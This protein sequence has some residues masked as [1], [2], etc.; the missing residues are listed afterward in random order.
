MV[1]EKKQQKNGFFNINNL[2]PGE[3][4]E[5]PLQRIYAKRLLVFSIF[6]IVCILWPF[7][8]FEENAV[9]WLQNEKGIEFYGN[10][11]VMSS[12]PP[13]KLFESLVDGDGFSLEVWLSTA[14]KYQK[15]PARIISY[16]KNPYLR[17]FTLAQDGHKLVM[18]LRTTKTNKNGVNPFFTVLDVFTNTEKMHIAITYDGKW[19]TIYVNGNKR[20]RKSIPGGRFENWDRKFYL[21]L[22][23]EGTA[24]RPWFGK[25]FQ[26]K[27]HN[28]ILAPVEIQQSYMFE[29]EGNLE[30]YP[31]A[32]QKDGL[33]VDYRFDEGKGSLIGDSVGNNEPIDLYLPKF[34]RKCGVTLLSWPNISIQQILKS[35]DVV[36]NI[37][38]FV[39]FGFLMHGVIRV[40][41]GLSWK[42][43]V[44]VCMSGIA[45]SLSLE[46]LQHLSIS[47]NSSL[48]D[49]INNSVGTII[50]AMLG[51]VYIKHV[52][53]YWRQA[54]QS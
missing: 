29:K 37:I 30:K 41:Y 7:D 19:Q 1:K 48:L 17:N 46:I 5:D 45:L 47:R 42:A 6:L 33:A 12:M 11:I 24:D 54:K 39:P 10:G 4:I 3:T 25:L 9:R 44:V 20:G 14:K 51:C 27:I 26:V 32:M 31:P 18:R 34:L 49:L 36:L 38:L 53:A 2:L 43:F 40:K 23:N 52:K 22:G 13:K 21:I 8:F 28:R 35:S 50:G 16:S 15:G